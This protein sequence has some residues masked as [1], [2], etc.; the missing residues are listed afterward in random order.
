MFNIKKYLS[1]I[2]KQISLF[3]SLNAMYTTES[4]NFDRS[5]ERIV[6]RLLIEFK[7]EDR[8]FISPSF[9][10]LVQELYFPNHINIEITNNIASIKNLNICVIHT[11]KINKNNL[12]NKNELNM[13]FI[14][15]DKY[16]YTTKQ[17]IS[18][19]KY[20]IF[21]KYSTLNQIIIK[22]RNLEIK[23]SNAR[24]K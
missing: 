16:F 18:K 14:I 9:R 6:K 4:I 2:S 1:N 7:N 20:L 17:N 22:L 11:N 10:F 19:Q 24:N 5:F 12:I 8:I 13:G 3:K 21:L 23:I 15:E